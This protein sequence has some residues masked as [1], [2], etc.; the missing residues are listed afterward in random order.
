MIKLTK[1]EILKHVYLNILT[2]ECLTF[3]MHEWKIN[4]WTEVLKVHT[5][6]PYA[7]PNTKKLWFA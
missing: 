1:N 2:E 3:P 4:G 5:A 7:S 6:D